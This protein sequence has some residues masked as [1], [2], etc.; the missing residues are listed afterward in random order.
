M[1][2]SHALLPYPT[3]PLPDYSPAKLL[4]AH[5]GFVGLVRGILVPVHDQVLLAVL[6]NVRLLQPISTPR[7]TTK[8]G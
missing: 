3:T 7:A 1:D 5:L 8:S 4:A 2:T 6:V